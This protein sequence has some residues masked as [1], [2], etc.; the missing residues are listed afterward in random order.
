MNLKQI[1]KQ[2]TVEMLSFLTDLALGNMSI[3]KFEEAHVYV[4]NLCEGTYPRTRRVYGA[5][6]GEIAD[7]TSHVIKTMFTA[8]YMVNNIASISCKMYTYIWY[9]AG[10]DNY[11]HGFKGKDQCS[12]LHVRAFIPLSCLFHLFGIS[13]IELFPI[14]QSKQKN[15][16]R[17]DKSTKL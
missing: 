2:F 9:I 14:H 13:Q 10:D 15:M 5:N 6:K 1:H 7:P 16:F 3:L 8:G 12:L 17:D 4:W 11:F